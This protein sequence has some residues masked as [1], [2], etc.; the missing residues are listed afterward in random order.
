MLSAACLLSDVHY[1]FTL[2]GPRLP[3][4][5]FFLESLAQALA[6]DSRYGN[7]YFERMHPTVVA[8]R[9]GIEDLI[10]QCVD[11][12][13]AL[14][15]PSS[16]SD[17]VSGTTSAATSAQSSPV[18]GPLG[19]TPSSEGSAMKVK[20]GRGQNRKM[21][22][23]FEGERWEDMLNRCWNQIQSAEESGVIQFPSGS[24]DDVLKEEPI[25][26]ISQVPTAG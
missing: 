25:V 15:L 16:P 20:R 1:P 18:L 19:A 26:T 11:L 3:S 4:F 22:L 24:L 14:S 23:Q 6:V 7:D 21:S 5:R 13:S 8:T 2:E 10:H 17:P 12:E 9:N